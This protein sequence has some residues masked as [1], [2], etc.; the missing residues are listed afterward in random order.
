[1]CSVCPS[2]GDIESQRHPMPGGRVDDD[3]GITFFKGFIVSSHPIDVYGKSLIDSIGV[4]LGLCKC[5]WKP[6]PSDF[7][8]LSSRSWIG[9]KQHKLKIMSSFLLKD[10]HYTSWHSKE[11]GSIVPSAKKHVQIV[12][13]CKCSLKQ[14]RLQKRT[15]EI[16]QGLR[17]SVWITFFF[18]NGK[19]NIIKQDDLHVNKK[20]SFF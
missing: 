19:W 2:P 4:K 15:K 14:P 7:P 8:I 16:L 11:I 18:P 1:M 6:H 13:I 9:Y 10:I 20:P 5:F 3:P 17:N 12:H